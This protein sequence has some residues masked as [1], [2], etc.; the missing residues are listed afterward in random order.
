VRY[1]VIVMLAL[2]CYEAPDYSG[3]RFKCDDKHAC[4]AGQQCV[5]GLCGGG[6]SGGSGTDS[7]MTS[8]SSVACAGETCG[9]NQ[10]CCVDF[11]TSG[12]SCIATGAQCNGFS[13][14]CD[15]KEDCSGGFCCESG[16]GTIGCGAACS[17]GTICL[18]A[19]DCPST[20]PMCCM[21]LGGT[22]E[23]WGRCN[24]ACP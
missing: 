23:P 21:G 20:T 17:S 6:G 14:T 7:G 19:A 5:N 16:G 11:V 10:K 1:V 2:G 22:M 15:G 9:A 8:Q 12:V 18:E 4:P 3:A 13:A 24:V